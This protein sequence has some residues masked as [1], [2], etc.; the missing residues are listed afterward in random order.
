MDVESVW[1]QFADGGPAAR[2]V[3]G[4]GVARSEGEITVQAAR[5]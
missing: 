4:L 1:Q 5:V 2:F 3:D